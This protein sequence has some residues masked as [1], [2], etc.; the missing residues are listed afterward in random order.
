MPE[1]LKIKTI[2]LCTDSG[3]WCSYSVGENGV[4]KIVPATKNG[5]MALITYY[6]IYSGEKL[7]AD[8]H[9]VTVVSYV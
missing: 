7:I 5:E 8:L 1:E 2:E 3:L 9:R 4:T 6:E